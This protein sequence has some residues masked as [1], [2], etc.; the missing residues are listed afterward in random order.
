[1]LVLGLAQFF[2]G[3]F[4]DRYGRK[5]VIVVGFAIAVIGLAGSAF[6]RSIDMLYV[7][8]AVTAFGTAGCTVISRAIIVDVFHDQ[9]S[10]K[11]AFSYFAM[12]SQFSPAIA[13][14]LGGVIQQYWGWQASF[15]AFAIVTGLGLIFILLAMNETHVQNE[16]KSSCMRD[17]YAPYLALIRN[18]KFISYSIAS[19]LIFAFTI[20]YYSTSPYA[21]HALGYSPII[22]SLFYLSYSAAILLG[23]WLMG[24][25]LSEIRSHR[26]YLCSIIAYG[27][28]CLISLPMDISNSGLKIIVFS[29]FLGG[30]CGVAAP[31]ALVL[32][33]SGVETNRGATSA[34][35]GAIKMFFT[36]I[37][38]LVFDAVHIVD[39]TSLVEVFIVFVMLLWA[40]FALDFA[41]EK[42]MQEN[43]LA[44]KSLM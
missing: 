40:I 1:M 19:A 3:S 13:P 29:F 25:V 38:L 15:T 32:S 11:K 23:A 27:A 30:I 34:L 33:M 39:F 37:F 22:N 41:R 5:P 10:L 12:S 18:F 20:G 28:L 16:K 31:L 26:L 44:H 43:V 14:L 4:S 42:R 35:Q 6:C 9:S 17:V 36:G 8:R 24:S 21:F 2:Y 7:A